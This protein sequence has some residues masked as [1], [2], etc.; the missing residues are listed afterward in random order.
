MHCFSLCQTH[1]PRLSYIN[2]FQHLSFPWVQLLCNSYVTVEETETGQAK[3][4]SPRVPRKAQGRQRFLDSATSSQ[5]H[6]CL[7]P[8]LPMSHVPSFQKEN[9]QEELISEPNQ[10]GLKVKPPCLVVFREAN[11]LLRPRST[12]LFGF[13]S[14]PTSLQL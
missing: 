4:T 9:T 8:L 7:Y 12:L 6:T 10:N 14:S 5:G 1:S 2:S 3:P 13:G 11:C